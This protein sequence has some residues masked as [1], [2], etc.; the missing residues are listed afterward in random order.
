MRTCVVIAF[1]AVCA[2]NIFAQ[3]PA[4]TRAQAIAADFSKNK[5]VVK[6]K[7]GVRTEKF[8]DVRSEAVVRQNVRD[9]A[10][11]YEVADLGFVINIQAAS[12]GRLE[13][14][15]FENNQ[16]VRFENVRVEGALLTASR[17]HQNGSTE[18]F[19]GVF[20]NRTERNSP[21]DAGIT[22]FGLGVVLATPV[23]AHGLTL[24]KLFYQAK[25]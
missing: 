15:G 1:I 3:T 7:Y 23:T 9:Y 11:V 16:Q 13:M 25:R 10:G 17:I 12:D 24:D 6:E 19:E 4:Q 18:K 20:L 2:G 22:T 5:H 21:S 8:K 14:N